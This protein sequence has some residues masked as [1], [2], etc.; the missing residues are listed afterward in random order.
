MRA[1]SREIHFLEMA[2]KALQVAEEAAAAGELTMI[3]VANMAIPIIGVFAGIVS[4]VAG[5]S[6]IQQRGTGIIP[7]GQ[8]RGGEARTIMSSGPVWGHAGETIGRLGPPEAIGGGGEGGF[9]VQVQQLT[10]ARD[11]EDAES[12]GRSFAHIRA[13]VLS[14][15][16][17][18]S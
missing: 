8:T 7:V 13:G 9:T 18:A 2:F 3:D 5:A 10:L 16:I 17:P 1:V 12:V 15:D 6:L 11:G 14:T 4:M